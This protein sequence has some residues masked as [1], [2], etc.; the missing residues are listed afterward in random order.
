ML[1]LLSCLKIGFLSQCTSYCIFVSDDN[2][3]RKKKSFI[4]GYS[5]SAND[6]PSGMGFFPVP[7]S[8]ENTIIA[9]FTAETF[10]SWLRS[11]ACLLWLNYSVKILV[12]LWLKR[13]KRSPLL[14]AGCQSL[15][16]T[17][18]LVEVSGK[19]PMTSLRFETEKLNL[20]LDASK[21]SWCIV[22]ESFSW[23]CMYFCLLRSST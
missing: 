16:L 21:T 6:K 7:A 8:T 4:L 3:S 20:S 10:H 13:A 19:T 5:C 1:I 9:D 22:I 12:V 23:A 15:L 18:V 17:T 14:V 2:F 11:L